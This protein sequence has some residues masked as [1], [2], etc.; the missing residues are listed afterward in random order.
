MKNKVVLITGSSS[1]IGRETALRFASA[2]A[3]LVL[4]YCKGKVRG[5]SVE[6]R[7]LNLGAAAALLLRLD[8]TDDRSIRAAVRKVLRTFG[9]VDILINNAGTGLFLPLKD[10]RAKDIERQ[11]RTN[12]EGLIK[13]TQ[14]FLPFVTKR[15]I[16][17]ASAAGEK[18]YSEMVVYSASKFGVRGFTQGLALEYPRL[19]VCCVNPDM[20][21]T[22]LSGN[23]GRPASEVA[24]VIFRVAAGKLRVKRGGDVDVWEFLG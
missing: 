18:A 19:S 7:C 24:D 17:I 3:R 11:V 20:T 1:G 5:R 21:A 14:V 10:Q 12:L 4:T 22:R 8:V 2:G 9:S 23:E 6:Q 13:T 16:N 15:I